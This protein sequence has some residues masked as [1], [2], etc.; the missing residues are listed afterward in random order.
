MTLVGE[1]LS[2]KRFIK[3]LGLT[4]ASIYHEQVRNIFFKM[5][6]LERLYCVIKDTF[7]AI[8]LATS[9]SD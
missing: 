6:P 7:K 1:I 3:L 9:A 5:F 4:A 8:F 2:V